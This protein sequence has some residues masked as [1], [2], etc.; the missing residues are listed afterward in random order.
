MILF[1]ILILTEIFKISHEIEQNSNETNNVSSLNPGR[2]LNFVH[3]ID[4]NLNNYDDISNLNP[5]ENN[6]NSDE[7]NL[8]FFY[9]IE[10]NIN[11]NEIEKN[12][13]FK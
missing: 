10:Q 3:E 13:D 5:D 4:Q 6:L 2:N 8:I 7:H 9:K 12:S 1:Q 11:F